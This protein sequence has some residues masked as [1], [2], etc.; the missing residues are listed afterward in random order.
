MGLLSRL[1]GTHLEAIRLP[2]FD[3]GSKAVEISATILREV[4]DRGSAGPDGTNR[5]CLATLFARGYLFGFSES[6]IQRFGIF[7][8]IESLAL[9]TVVHTKMFGGQVGWLFVQDALRGQGQAEFDRG[10]TAG[11]DDFL[12]W[13]KDRS[14]TPQSLT[15]YL[16]EG[17]DMSSPGAATG[18]S[19]AEPGIETPGVPM[20]C[21]PSTGND[22]LI[23][24]RATMAAASDRVVMTISLRKRLHL[25]PVKPV[26][27]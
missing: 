11:A 15:E 27:H 4:I 24:K 25:K 2:N 16:L 12:R 22:A 6:C 8:E 23:G 21:E 14:N 20:K 13:L 10:Q 5:G 18:R 7:D 17:D 9:I 1:F 3:A 19:A 26:S